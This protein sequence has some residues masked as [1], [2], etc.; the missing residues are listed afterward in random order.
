[1]RAG[2]SLICLLILLS[3]CTSPST[4]LEELAA[5]HAHRLITLQTAQFD[6]RAALPNVMPTAAPMRIY[7]EGDGRAWVT[8]QQPSL[9][10]T[11]RD[12]L[13][14]QLALEDPQPSIYLARPCQY[15]SSPSCT[16]RYWTDARFAEEVLASLDQALDQL[17]QRYGNSDFELIGY[18]GGGT[19]ALLLATRRNDIAQV[20][21]LAGNLSPRRWAEL[22]DLTPLHNS[23]EPLDFAE[24]LQAVPQR[25]LAGRDD[26]TV[27]A[28]LLNEYAARLGSADCLEL[29]LIDGVS[30]HAG[31]REHWPGWRDQPIE[32]RKARRPASEQV[33]AR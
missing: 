31:W 23:L 14:A 7:L 29:H 24:R 4:R 30:H 28:S 2:V 16:P 1:M 17:K 19:L 27:L 25:H 12:Q 32:C 5:Q 20:Q 8:A 15:L 13:V 9:D 3:A 6:L 10:P 33:E 18:S 22:L 26:Q 11:P 21:T